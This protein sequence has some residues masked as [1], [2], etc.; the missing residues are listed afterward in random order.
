MA[1][2]PV[3]LEALQDHRPGSLARP[4]LR[5]TGRGTGGQPV[6]RGAGSPLSRPLFGRSHREEA[7]PTGDASLFFGARAAR[8]H[9]AGETPALPFRTP[10]LFALLSWRIPWHNRG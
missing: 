9:G 3:L 8:P 4:D 7:W 2:F 6:L 5:Y 10:P 1:L